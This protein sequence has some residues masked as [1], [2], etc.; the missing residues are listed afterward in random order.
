MKIYFITS[1]ID[2]ITTPVNLL[3]P[4]LAFVKYGPNPITIGA[5]I[6]QRFVYLFFSIYSQWPVPVADCRWFLIRISQEFDQA[7]H[8]HLTRYRIFRFSVSERD[9]FITFQIKPCS[10]NPND[11]L[12][13]KGL[14]SGVNP[15]IHFVTGVWYAIIVRCPHTPQ[16]CSMICRSSAFN[17][18]FFA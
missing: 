17:F 8:Q 7:G 5:I 2:L 16:T 9:P 6:H 13:V 1:P 3:P 12:L 11:W 4:D 18:D 10:D 15:V 14:Y